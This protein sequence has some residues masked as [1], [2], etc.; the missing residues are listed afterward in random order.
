M[1]AF[2][3]W[4]L[5]GGT[6]WHSLSTKKK[7]SPIITFSNSQLGSNPIVFPCA[8]LGILEEVIWYTIKEWQEKVPHHNVHGVLSWFFPM[9]SV[10]L[11]I[12]HDAMLCECN[13]TI[14]V[15]EDLFKWETQSPVLREGGRD[16]GWSEV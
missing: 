9:E 4:R 13:N 5:K 3:G 10:R 2:M 8:L 11:S 6:W 15:D 1:D 14:M 7:V 12:L 16:G